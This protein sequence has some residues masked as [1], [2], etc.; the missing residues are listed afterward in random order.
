M[1]TYAG[2]LVFESVLDSVNPADQFLTRVARDIFSPAVKVVEDDCGTMLGR[3]FPMAYDLE[4]RVELATGLR[5]NQ[6]RIR[7]LISDEI[8]R[9]AIRTLDTCVS[10]GG[11]CRKCY[12]A[13]FSDKAD[14]TVGTH[15]VIPPEYILFAETVMVPPAGSI[16]L[17]ALPQAYDK[18]LTFADG[19]LLGPEISPLS[20]GPRPST[21]VVTLHYVSEVRSPYMYWLAGTYSGSLLGMGKLPAPPLHLPPKTLTGLLGETQVED[22]VD[23]IS[24]F[25]NVP[26]DLLAY[27]KDVPSALEKATFAIALGVIYS[28]YD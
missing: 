3:V 18:V 15:V 16:S 10:S 25:T 6:T 7:S 27:C 28:D 14:V 23:H 26:A 1:R 20:G 11:V 24:G 9:V 21:D 5:L 13:T 17:A 22:I 12:R 8:Y 4:G 2:T 19:V